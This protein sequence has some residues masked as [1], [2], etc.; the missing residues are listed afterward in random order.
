METTRSSIKSSMSEYKSL[1]S[2]A[3]GLEISVSAFC[4]D[5]K[6]IENIALMGVEKEKV[7]LLKAVLLQRTEYWEKK[8]REIQK[9]VDRLL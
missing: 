1:L 2:E 3:L 4:S 7:L 6:T 5:I 8:I 9:E